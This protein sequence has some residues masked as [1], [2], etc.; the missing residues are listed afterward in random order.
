MTI[1]IDVL[2]V[3]N[4]YVNY[5][6][7]LITAKLSGSYLKSLRCVAA[8]VYGSLFSLMILAPQLPEAVNIAIKL[9]AA[10][11]VVM[12]A[13]GIHDI[14]RLIKNS[15]AFYGTNFL[16]AGGIYA[17]YVWLEPDFMHFSNSCFYIDFSLLLLIA[18][19]A[20]FYLAACILR[21]LW[22][23]SPVGDY[24][25]LIRIGERLLKIDGLADTGNCLVDYFTGKPVIICS[26]EDI[27]GLPVGVGTRI[28]PINTVS[29]GS[30]IEIFRPDEVM[31]CSAGEKKRRNADVMIGLGDAQGKAIFN[32]K[33][34]NG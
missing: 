26:R 1:Y 4:I 18:A 30:L 32:P 10:V 5:F 8:S 29:G 2:I 23:S 28:I 9:G 24:S 33:L 27:G 19:T 14:K 13:F 11:T 15:A 16:L 21:R 20:V 31:I 3:L 17:A 25:V 6:L 12:I 22:D 7:L 34:L